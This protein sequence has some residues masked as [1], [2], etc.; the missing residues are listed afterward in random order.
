M[1]KIMPLP[2]FF[3]LFKGEHVLLLYKNLITPETAFAENV[4]GNQY[5]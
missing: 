1:D 2:F 3:F 5:D 4:Q